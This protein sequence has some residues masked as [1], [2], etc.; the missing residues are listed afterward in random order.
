MMTRLLTSISLRSTLDIAAVD[1]LNSTAIQ[2]SEVFVYSKNQ[3]RNLYL[4]DIVWYQKMY[5]MYCVYL[6]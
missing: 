6:L 1:I 2:P 5:M 4:H 3:K